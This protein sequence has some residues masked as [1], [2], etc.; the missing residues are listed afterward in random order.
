M[1]AELNS[2][3]VMMANQIA[4]AFEGQRGDAVAETAG[5]IR[6][7]WPSLMRDQLIRYRQHGGEGLSPTAQAALEQIASALTPDGLSKC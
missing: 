1:S 6:A 5:H 2:R 3:L 4:T 7:F